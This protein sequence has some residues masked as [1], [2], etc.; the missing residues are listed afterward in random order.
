MTER[1]QQPLQEKT[2]VRRGR[3]A[4]LAAG[5]VAAALAAACLAVCVIAAVMQSAPP[6][7]E[8]LGVELGGLNRQEIC[9]RWQLRGPK[10]VAGQSIALEF[11]GE[12]VAR[13]HLDE[14]GV[15]VTPEAAAQAVWELAHGDGFF[16]NGYR[17]VESIFRPASVRAQ[18]S[19]DRDTLS[20][21]AAELAEELSY[22]SVDGSYRLEE[23]R[24]DGFYVT[25][26]ADG[27]RIDADALTAAL[28]Q[29]L[30]EQSLAPIACPG[31]VLPGQPL[32][33][34]SLHQELCGPVQ[35]ARYD[36]SRGCVVEGRMGMDFAAASVQSML[37]AARPGQELLVPADITYPAINKEQ[38]EQVLFRDVLAEYT[39][40][41]SGTADRIHNVRLAAGNISGQSVPSYGG[42]VCQVSS[43]L[44]NAALLAD[45]EIVSRDCHQFCQEYVPLGCDATVYWPYLDFQLR[46][47]TDYPLQ[48]VTFWYN[49]N[50]TVRILGT[51]TD[52]H[53]VRITSEVV[54]TLEW[55]TKYEETDELNEG[56]KKVKQYPITG[57]VVKTWRWVYDGSG[58]L[59]RKDFEDTSRYDSRDK[60]VLVGTRPVTPLPEPVPDPAPT[61]PA[62]PAAP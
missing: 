1:E 52:D 15:S 14:L 23:G 33:L 60:I 19:I 53:Y 50:V 55:E 25:R 45:L 6:G 21:R 43:T 5:I 24:T 2:P 30:E 22:A 4:A 26:Y 12:T 59:L 36:K 58:N 10:A 34:R 44:Y 42:G 57:Y 17:L 28:A 18:W 48:I 8:L 54:S 7:V 11:Q 39:T 35:N 38:M 49:N 61:T 32:D 29:A 3:R 47:N 56:Q 46:N 37:A 27:R 51:K 62:E 41:V 9:Q 40:Y 16:R 20:R 13:L 31:E